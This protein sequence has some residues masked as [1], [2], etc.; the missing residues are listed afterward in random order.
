MSTR[1]DAGGLVEALVAL[2]RPGKRFS[3]AG[4][5]KLDTCVVC[6]GEP[7]PCPTIRLVCDATGSPYPEQRKTGCDGMLPAEDGGGWVI[8]PLDRGHEP[9]GCVPA[10]VVFP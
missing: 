9:N 3:G 6:S 1:I 5:A 2:H 4:G 7:F 8:C 10:S